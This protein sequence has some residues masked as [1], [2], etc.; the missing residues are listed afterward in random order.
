MADKQLKP[1]LLARRKTLIDCLGRAEAFLAEYEAERDQSQAQ[2]RISHLDNLWANLEQVQ[3][4]LEDMEA[5]TE[6][7]MLHDEVRAMFEPRLF[8]IKANL[9]TKLTPLLDNARIP[10]PPHA[11]STLSGIK[12]PTIALPEFDG[13]YNDWLTFHD[14]FLA[15]IHNNMDV[16]AIQKFHYLKAAVKAEAIQL[17]TELANMLGK[18]GFVLRKWSFNELA[19]LQGLDETQIATKSTVH[20]SPNETIET[21]GICWE[22]EADCL[23]FES[24]AA[25]EVWPPTKR[26]ILSSIARLYDPLGIIAPIV[27]RAKILMQELWQLSCEWDDPVPEPVQ[28]KWKE[29]HAELP[30]ISSYRVKRYAFLPH[31]A[32]QLHTFAD[33]S[34]MAYGACSYVR[35][36][37]AEGNVQI[38]LL[39]SKS[40]VAPLKSLTVPRLELCAA[41]LASHLHARVKDAI[42]TCV[43]KSYFWSDS[44]VTLHWLR[45]PPNMWQTY[46]AHRV[47]EIQHFT[48][49]CRWSHIFG[50]E[51]PADIV[52]RGFLVNDLWKYGPAWLTYSERD[53]PVSVLPT[54][55]EN[56]LECKVVSAISTTLPVPLVHPWFLRWSSYTKMVHVIAY[57]MRFVVNIRDKTRT[58]PQP[59]MSDVS[60]AL[61]VEQIRKANLFLIRQVQDEAFHHEMKYIERNRSIS[62]G[63]KIRPFVDEERV[64]RVGG[65]LSLSQLPDQ[66]KHPILLPG[67]HPFT[68]LLTERYHIKTLHGGGRLLL[69]A[70]REEYWPLQG[71]RLARSIVR[72]CFRCTRVN[73]VPVQQQIGQLPVHR[74]ITS[75]PFNV[76]GIDYA[77]PVYLKPIHKRAPA[78][79]AYFCV[80]ICFAT[81]AVHIELASDLSTQA[82]LCAFRRFIARRGRPAH[83]HSDNGKNFEGAKNEMEKLFNMLKNP[84]EQEIIHAACI[85]EGITWCLTPPKA[86]HF[87]GLW[88]AAVKVAKK[89]LF[90]QLG[91]SRLSF[92]DMSTILAQIESQINSRPLLPLSE[93]PNDLSA[94]TLAHFL[95]G[96]TMNALSDSDL[97]QVPMNR[98]DHYQKLQAY[99]QNFWEHW[100]RE[101]L[102]ELQIDTKGYSRN[103][104]IQPG[105]MVIVVDE[106]QAPIRWPLARIVS[107]HPGKNNIT[108]VITLRTAKGIIKRPTAKISV[109]CRT[110]RQYPT[111][112]P[113]LQRPSTL[114]RT[115]KCHWAL[116]NSLQR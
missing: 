33:A 48:S 85:A 20:F 62:P 105:I 31:S 43:V 35:C 113:L 101:Y 19:V 82:F 1:Q 4:S 102:Q 77:G 115:G 110:P 100:K 71:R 26:S 97:R 9:L 96:T 27:I 78:E 28:R 36:E 59:M 89:H 70:M 108:R 47:A 30:E 112:N 10:Q 109:C 8:A 24:N 116:H 38:R 18:G 65:R 111:R 22:P 84:L 49:G 15:L 6:G 17:R 94:L 57:C 23:R 104:E 58:Q 53:W 68:R 42:D 29:L 40:R 45:S 87:G 37:D 93:D 7:R 13:N 99:T 34:E 88:E 107:V 76:T 39:A 106:L 44:A 14:T 5:A 81:K 69:T 91:A 3:M 16:P 63:S 74:V 92:E 95:I 32:I 56:Q 114:N 54:V 52:S 2:L 11:N 73:P 90:R 80:F 25:S 72:N 41:V 60:K 21:L 75:R 66:T 98:L 64:L 50:K 51:N 55:P 103:D 86:P 79:K 67:F 12:L 61:S 83:V 46:V